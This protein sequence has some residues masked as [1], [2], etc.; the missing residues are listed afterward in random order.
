[1]KGSKNKTKQNKTKTHSVLTTYEDAFFPLFLVLKVYH[2][3][4][5]LISDFV[6]WFP[7][8]ETQP[9]N[10]SPVHHNAPKQTE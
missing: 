2:S 5:I 6:S 8:Q 3:Y 1:M 7:A 9:T 4:C 10:Y